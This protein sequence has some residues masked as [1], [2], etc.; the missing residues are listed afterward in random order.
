MLNIWHII[1]WHGGKYSWDLFAP[2]FVCG[3]TGIILD[4]SAP[5]FVRDVTG[6]TPETCLLY[7]ILVKF[8][9]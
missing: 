3:M 2:R 5:R 4:L 9:A 6:V 7:E 8:E 1:S